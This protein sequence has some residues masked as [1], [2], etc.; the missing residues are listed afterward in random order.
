MFAALLIFSHFHP[1]ENGDFQPA[2]QLCPCSFEQAFSQLR[3]LAIWGGKPSLWAVINCALLR[4]SKTHYV[5]ERPQC[6]RL[7]PRREPL[8]FSLF[9]LPSDKNTLLGEKKKPQSELL[10]CS[11]FRLLCWRF[12]LAADVLWMTAEQA[13]GVLGS[14]PVWCTLCFLFSCALNAPLCPRFY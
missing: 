8:M 12:Y 14:G 3:R 7:Y 4:G 2:R 9:R 10:V 13:L 1:K 11:V 6:S 5:Q